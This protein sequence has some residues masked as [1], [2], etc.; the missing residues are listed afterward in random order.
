MTDAGSTLISRYAAAPGALDEMLDADGSVRPHYRAAVE[1]LSVVSDLG[2]KEP[3]VGLSNL[4]S[5]EVAIDFANYYAASLQRPTLVYL[6]VRMR[7]E[8][9][10][11]RAAAGVFAATG[12]GVQRQAGGAL[13][14]NAG[15]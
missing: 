11:V 14:R 3:Y 1:Q 13:W 9:G 15:F 4:V 2:L 6:G 10:E 12:H 8:S 5:G 7:A